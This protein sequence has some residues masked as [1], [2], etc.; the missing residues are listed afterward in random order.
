MK[1]VY[2]EFL[3]ALSAI[4]IPIIIHLF[5][6]R[7]FK[8]VY[9]SNIQFLKE[10]QIQTQSRSRLKHWLVLVSRILAITALVL[11]FAQ[12]Y[13][14]SAN[15]TLTSATNVAAVFIDNS[16]SMNATNDKGTL[17]DDTKNKARE[18]LQAYQ[19]SDRFQLITND[20]EG[21]QQR[22][23]NKEEFLELLEEIEIT[24]ASK[25]MS[26][27]YSRQKEAVKDITEGNRNFY[28]I[29]DFQQ[30]IADVSGFE[31]DTSNSLYFIPITANQENNLYIDSCWFKAPIRQ[32]NQPDELIA[33]VKNVSDE[34][35]DNIPIKLKIN[36]EQKALASFSI[37]AG[38]RKDVVLSFTNT[39]TGIHLAELGITDYPI[40][41]DDVF[42]FSYKVAEQIPVLSIN[43]KEVSGAINKL[44]GAD[45]YFQLTNFEE[46]NINYSAFSSN[47]FIIVN[48]LD[49]PSSGL[50]QELAR[51]V[52][53]GGHVLVIP[54]K[55]IDFE[56]YN[57]LLLALGANTVESQAAYL[58]ENPGKVTGIDYESDIYNNVFREKSEKIDLPKVGLHYNFTTKTRSTEERI[59]TLG[60]GGS[61][62]SR[63]THGKGKVYVLAVPLNDDSNFPKHAI[64]VPTL[65]NMA[66][67]SQTTGRLFYTIGRDEI[68]EL[69]NVA[70][71]A[72]NV[73]KIKDPKSEMEVIPGHRSSGASSQLILQDQIN[74][75][76]NYLLTIDKDTITGLSFNFDRKESD[77][78]CYTGDDIEKEAKKAGLE[79][80]Q[81]LQSDAR[82]IG[83]QL[84][85]LS[86][87][88][89]LWKLFLILA[90]VF[91]A[92]EVLL[93]KFW[94]G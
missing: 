68:V 14:P 52:E 33:R 29:S 47:F 64:F 36:G 93:L 30:S 44:F 28:F 85:Q 24:P 72:D 12:P 59:L 16:F 89:K 75:A 38:G 2:P 35:F 17:L 73:F 15:N 25:K 10:V 49:K 34:S 32:L 92:I 94:K 88:T 48:Q 57:E 58:A 91:L 3:A 60:N 62:L 87:G 31:P 41:Y 21:R 23:V 45:P 80:Y 84:K 22:L 19:A 55:D 83:S 4:A 20:F 76:N 56:P 13:L 69:P 39:E 63:F 40:T 78:T 43:G 90:L 50:V 70:I 79:G 74:Q 77:L 46:T 81:V 6:F 61:F 7:R 66:L 1:F 65:Y 11:A 71:T 26:D 51:F 53:N 86:Q 27:V 54:K 18:I 37:D 67:Y 42:Y 9:F 5:N 8:K 82:D